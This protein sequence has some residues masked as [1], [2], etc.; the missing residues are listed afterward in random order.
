MQQETET[1]NCRNTV[2]DCIICA[3]GASSRMGEWKPLLPWGESTLVGTSVAAALAA[4]C[5][6]I[7]VTGANA[8]M[9]EEQFCRTTNVVTVR[10]DEW[11]KGMVSSIR[12]GAAL[13][14]SEYFFVAHADMPL[15]KSDVYAELLAAAYREDIPGS[16]KIRVIRPRFEGTPGH[17]VLFDRNALPFIAA[18][19]DGESMKELLARCELRFLDTEER[20]AILDLDDPEI[21]AAELA[22]FD[23]ERSARG[24]LVLTG[25]KGMGKTTRIRQLFDHAATRKLNAVL[26]R[27]TGTGRDAQGRATGF[28]MEMTAVYASGG[29]ETLT[30]PLARL[31][32]DGFEPLSRTSVGPFVFDC[33]V[34]AQA[35]RF[36]NGFI[37]KTGRQPRFIGIDE[38]GKLE[39]ERSGGLMPVLETAVAAVRSARAEGSAQH[40]VCSARHDT[41]DKLETF[42]ARECLD[43]DI[44]TLR[45]P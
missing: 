45:M 20:G 2:C 13:V 25:G 32:G 15:V 44:Q 1:G 18:L 4:G 21:Y 38:I 36:V 23:L 31:E 42:L 30:L 5:R 26:V 39:L 10:N 3:A 37:E 22:R 35:L 9:L 41:L 24:M 27:Q 6:V 8:G 33:A 19:P 34:F 28:D 17:P 43:A 29:T 11:K 16:G 14:S 12:C 40:A 7:L